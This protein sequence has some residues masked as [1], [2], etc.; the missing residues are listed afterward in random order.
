MSWIEIV[1]A[2][3]GLLC[4]AL[5]AARSIW[6]YPTGIA[7][8]AMFGAVFF[9]ARLYSD[10][11]L[12]GFFVAANLYGWLNWQRS[13]EQ[14]GDVVVETMSIGARSRWAAGCLVAMLGW[15]WLMHAQTDASY[16]WADAG[17]AI[18]SVAA[19]ILMAR[20]AWEN[21]VLWIGVDLASLPLYLAKQ[22]WVTAA[23][24]AA[25]L[26]LA[27]WGLMQWRRAQRQVSV[28]A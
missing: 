6:T 24:Y 17:I 4:V 3:I 25:Y 21:W 19:Q 18:V 20:R 11:L 15:G 9:A 14:S 8:V 10:A 12:Q 22:L 27:V 26:V 23:L 7:S 1:A 28:A 16:P 5:G 13:R 2:L